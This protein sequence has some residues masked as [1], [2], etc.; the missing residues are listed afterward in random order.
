MSKKKNSTRNRQRPSKNRWPLLVA[1]GG[2]LL[3]ILA[4]FALRPGRA[5]VEVTGQA[6]LKTDHQRI[7]LG[8]VALGTR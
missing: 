3:I 4:L 8:T 2:G 7:D 5:A 6:K 1:L